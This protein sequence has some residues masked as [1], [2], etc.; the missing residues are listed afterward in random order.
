[1]PQIPSRAALKFYSKKSWKSA[2]CRSSKKLAEPDGNKIYE[3]ILKEQGGELLESI[4]L[5]R[6]KN[7]KSIL[8]KTP[9][10]VASFRVNQNESNLS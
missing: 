3:I 8:N 4:R 10:M 5:I 1:M 7:A 6:A 9:L 2:P